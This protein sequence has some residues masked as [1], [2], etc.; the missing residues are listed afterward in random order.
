MWLQ[1]RATCGTIRGACA[2]LYMCWFPRFVHNAIPGTSHYVMVLVL[3][4]VWYGSV[5]FVYNKQLCA[6]SDH[7]NGNDS[8]RHHKSDNF[9]TF[10][11]NYSNYSSY[12]SA[13]SVTGRTGRFLHVRALCPFCRQ[14]VHVCTR[15]FVARSSPVL[16]TRRN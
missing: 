5:N 15:T 12:T 6:T 10:R 9:T 2:L 16:L 11:S 1:F 8:T 13:S 14:L 4:H 3:Y 7:L